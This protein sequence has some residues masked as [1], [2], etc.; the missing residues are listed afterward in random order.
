MGSTDPK[1]EE[2]LKKRHMLMEEGVVFDFKGGLD[3]GIGIK[4][5]M[6]ELDTSKA[7]VNQA[8]MFEFDK[9]ARVA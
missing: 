1:G 7:R 4:R 9:L 5:Q 3:A 8:Y 2:L 6:D